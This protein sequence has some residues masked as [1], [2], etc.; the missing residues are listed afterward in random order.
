MQAHSQDHMDN[1]HSL[2]EYP[3]GWG[4]VRMENAYDPKHVSAV[5]SDPD[6]DAKLA[7][8]GVDFEGQMP[9]S[10]LFHWINDQ[11]GA[12]KTQP[13]E[14]SMSTR[15]CLGL[16]VMVLQCSVAWFH[17]TDEYGPPGDELCFILREQVACL[18]EICE[19]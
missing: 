4:V 7:Q 14:V 10:M 2:Y 13:P 6:L 19:R 11:M 9:R 3:G 15:R 18:K 8:A 12:V 17:G 5:L 1:I 16:L